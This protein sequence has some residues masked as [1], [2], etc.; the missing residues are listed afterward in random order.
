[1]KFPLAKQMVLNKVLHS[2]AIVAVASAD[3][4]TVL[5]GSNAKLFK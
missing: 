1:M 5:P 4:T 2:G 3:A